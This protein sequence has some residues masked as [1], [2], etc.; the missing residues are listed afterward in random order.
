MTESLL[1]NQKTLVK[2]VQP[3][4]SF[5]NRDF[6]LLWQG[7]LVS[8][9]GSQ[10]FLVGMMYW[11]MEATGSGSLMG[12]LMMLTMLP[13]VLLGPLG[14]TVADR[15]SRKLI[16][17]ICDVL[18]GI[19]VLILTGL[20]MTETTS[21]EVLIL[22]LLL[23]AASVGVIQAF[24][25]P[26]ILAAI[27]DLVPEERISAANSL[28]QFSYQFSSVL[29]Q[30]TGGL[31]YSF[32][33][34]PL[35]FLVDG[36]TFLFSA[37][38]E[39]FIK[40]PQKAPEKSVNGKEALASFRT[41]LLYGLRFVWRWVGMRDFLIMVGLVH[42]FAMP[43][44]VLMP[45]YAEFC[46]GKGADWYGF[47]MASFSGGSV[48][49]YVLAGT[50]SLAGR[51]RSQFLLLLLSVASILYGIL[52][53]LGNPFLAL[54]VI[55]FSGAMLGIFNVNTMTIIQTSVT[56][57]LRG[58]VMGL[59]MT[60]AN[61]ASPLGMLAGGIAADLTDKNIPLLYA[62]CG[63]SIVVAVLLLGTRRPVMEYLSP[64][65]GD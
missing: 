26:A 19:A 3:P 20:F 21:K 46:L 40:I 34:A 32:L 15:F 5:L 57:E 23:V 27:P 38:S 14:G 47:L 7:Q 22:C 10:A 65:A 29:G 11:A 18:S 50:F 51:M 42:F 33:G 56:S 55:F 58:R 53:F 4:R 28:N 48:T 24:F 62:F 44:I 13:G 41:D 12:V 37:L 36:L 31:V 9:I 1:R 35:L 52:G 49:G 25:R 45:F 2:E 17:V 59:V 43:F 16:I 39:S 30:G 6:F 60:I 64:N 8:Q 63:G 61:A 54:L